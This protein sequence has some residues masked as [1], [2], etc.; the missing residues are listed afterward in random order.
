MGNSRPA[1]GL[2]TWWRHG[3]SGNTEKPAPYKTEGPE[4]ADTRAARHHRERV[5][6]M[7]IAAFTR[8]Q[9]LAQVCLA[10]GHATNIVEL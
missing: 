2:F 8:M 7:T 10:I 3:G 1:R 4:N 6:D 5:V 9:I